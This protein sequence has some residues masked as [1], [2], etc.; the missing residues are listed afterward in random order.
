M[1]I[2]AYRL[3]GRDSFE[4]YSS[5]K[6]EVLDTLN[7]DPGKW[8]ILS[9][10]DIAAPCRFFPFKERLSE[11]PE[12]VKYEN[13]L[14]L[15]IDSSSLENYEN[16]V[17]KAVDEIKK[18]ACEKIVTSARK[19]IPFKNDVF[20]IFKAL[21]RK[22]PSAFV[23]F[24]STDDL[25]TWIGASPELLLSRK[26]EALK[27]M[28][29]AGTRASGQNTDKWDEKNIKE[30]EFVTRYIAETF[31]RL[32]LHCSISLPQTLRAGNIEHIMTLI[33]AMSDDK[34]EI[35]ELL[36]SLSP[37]PALCG[38]P[39][40][41]AMEF[42]A[43]NETDRMLYGGFGGPLFENGD[44]DLFVLIRCAC[45]NSETATLFAGG[46]ITELSVP[47]D[48]KLEIERKFETLESIFFNK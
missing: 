41:D 37:T 12:A 7:T 4:I 44:F 3:P 45:L 46:G 23:F 2:F 39:K 38:L 42:I 16:Y 22:Y 11:I 9:P 28:A 27:S 36:R 13:S 40:K 8:F 15:G 26:G 35:L 18:G 34:S 5:G 21:C 25:G 32:G 30:Q 47:A 24:I 17:A 6:P 19:V 1:N 31:G 33:S 43:N 20:P 29:L 10:F 14:D 48:E